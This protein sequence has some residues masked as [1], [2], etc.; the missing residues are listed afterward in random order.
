M[1]FKIREGTAKDMTSV[2]RLINELAVY[3]N[4]PDAVKINAAQ[5]VE[6]G[7]GKEILFHT[8]V[9]VIDGVIVGVAV[10]YNRFSTWDGPS[11]H[12]E[13]LIVTEQFRGKGIGKALYDKVLEFGLKS[14]KKRVEWVVLDWNT[15]AIEFY[16]S[17]GATML[18]DWNLCQMWEKDI[19]NYLSKNK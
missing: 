15:P 10:F 19:K 7:F 4:E 8:Y 11:L 3:E 9:A 5:L 17:T 12:L 2:L 14:G 1:S 16:K 18:E 6:H 13:D